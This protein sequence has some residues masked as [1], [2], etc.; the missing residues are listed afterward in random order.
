[1]LSKPERDAIH[2]SGLVHRPKPWDFILHSCAVL[3][4]RP[5]SFEDASEI[6]GASFM[7][8]AT[9]SDD[10]QVWCVQHR[11]TFRPNGPIES[12]YQGREDDDRA[13]YFHHDPL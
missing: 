11:L 3:I 8:S 13:N 6:L 12:I 4:N 7:Q 5:L 2:A 1:M 10:V 9:H